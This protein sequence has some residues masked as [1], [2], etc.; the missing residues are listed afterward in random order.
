[1]LTKPIAIVVMKPLASGVT[2]VEKRTKRSRVWRPSE[3]EDSG[4]H[5]EGDDG[6]ENGEDDEVGKENV[7]PG[8]RS[9]RLRGKPQQKYRY[10]ADV[11]EWENQR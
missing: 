4:E 9:E 11:F 7:P 5:D 10:P 1:M 3:E 6:E 2:K 8:K